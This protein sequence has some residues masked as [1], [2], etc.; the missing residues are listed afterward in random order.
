MAEFICLIGGLFGGW[1]LH[2]HRARIQRI[3]SAVNDE[4]KK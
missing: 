3:H 2:A 4:L 1:F